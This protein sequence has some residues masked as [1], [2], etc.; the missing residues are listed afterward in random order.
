MDLQKIVPR[1]RTQLLEILTMLSYRSSDLNHYLNEIAL[2][3]SQL[4]DSDWSI[5]TICQGETGKVLA[6]SQ[7]L[8]QDITYQMHGTLTDIV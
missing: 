2:G 5:V 8:P 6:S 4:I 7:P 1:E 3:V